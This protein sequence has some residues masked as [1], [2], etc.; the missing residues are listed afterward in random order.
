MVSPSPRPNSS[1][2][3]APP[4]YRSTPLQILPCLHDRGGRRLLRRLV[5]DHHLSAG[6]ALRAVLYPAVARL[7]LQLCRL[8]LPLRPPQCPRP[9]PQR[10]N[11]RGPNQS[12]SQ[13]HIFSQFL[14]DESFRT[15]ARACAG[16]HTHAKNSRARTH[17][18][19]HACTH[20][21][22]RGRERGRK[23]E[24]I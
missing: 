4:Q 24:R 8:R 13:R 20:E 12:S 23:W 10:R 1:S 15:H 9:R 3:P 21:R 19:T 6:V 18:H 7:R 2:P 17:I 5:L 16:V 22:V 11:L 14:T